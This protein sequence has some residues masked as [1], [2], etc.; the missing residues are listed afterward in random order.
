[1]FDLDPRSHDSREREAADPRD[2]E[3]LD[4]RDVFTRD[5]D[6]P[7]GLER[8]RVHVHAHREDYHLRG[9]EVGALATIGAFRVVAADDLRDD[10]GRPGDVR[11]GDLERLRSAGLIRAVAPLDRGDRTV[12]VTLTKRGREVLETHR[13]RG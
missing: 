9:S 3:S 8:E 1:M 5:L 6:L 11:H 2:A 4:P 7:R 12:I 10:H 13:S